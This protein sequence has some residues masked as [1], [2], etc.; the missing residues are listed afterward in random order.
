MRTASVVDVRGAEEI[1]LVSFQT[2]RTRLLGGTRTGGDFQ[3]GLYKLICHSWKEGVSSVSGQNVQKAFCAG[4]V[5][6][7]ACQLIY[8]ENSELPLECEELRVST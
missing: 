8:P 7:N 2:R 4:D 5:K 3:W 1:G 6:G